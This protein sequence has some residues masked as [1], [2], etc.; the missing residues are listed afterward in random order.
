MQHPFAIVQS[1]R[2]TFGQLA[3]DRAVLGISA[4]RLPLSPKFDLFFE[5]RAPEDAASE[6]S[7]IL[8]SAR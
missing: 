5:A 6:Q 7:P 3:E 8:R 1:S 4:V 2:A